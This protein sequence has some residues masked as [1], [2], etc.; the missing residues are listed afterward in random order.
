M[1]RHYDVSYTISAAR[2]RV[3]VAHGG[4]SAFYWALWGGLVQLP[5]GLHS[6]AQFFI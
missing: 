3:I 6:F 2:I 1:L 4:V 5:A